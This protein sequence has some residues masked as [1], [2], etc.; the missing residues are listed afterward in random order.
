ME[1]IFENAIEELDNLCDSLGVQ[2]RGNPTSIPVRI[3]KLHPDAIIP[4]KSTPGSA[5]YDLYAPKDVRVWPGRGVIPLGLAIELPYGY[6]ASIQS[7]SGYAS[8]GMEIIIDNPV[9]KAYNNSNEQQYSIRVDISVITGVVDSDYRDEIGVIVNNRDG[10][11]RTIRKGQKIAQM[12]IR[13]V[14]DAEWEEVDELTPTD[15]KGGFGSTGN[16]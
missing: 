1:E 5:G 10:L 9:T 8:K 14:E 11:T 6:E 15:H 12:I 7:R 13:K 16:N 4:R 3:K 2:R